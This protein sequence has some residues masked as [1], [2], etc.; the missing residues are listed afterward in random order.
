MDY[1]YEDEDDANGLSLLSPTGKYSISVPF[2][3][4]DNDEGSSRMITTSG[5]KGGLGLKGM[6][7]PPFSASASSVPTS[8]HHQNHQGHPSSSGPTT[9]TNMEQ[10]AAWDL[11]NLESVLQRKKQCLQTLRKHPPDTIPAT[12]VAGMTI[13]L[14]ESLIRE[15]T[16][17]LVHA[18][19]ATFL[20]INNNGVGGAGGVRS[21]VRSGERSGEDASSSDLLAERERQP[22]TTTTTTTENNNNNNAEMIPCKVCGRSVAASRFAPHLEKCM[23]LSGRS[24]RKNQTNKS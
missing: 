2:V 4:Q 15:I 9:P 1:Y 14:F 10:L 19:R 20:A 6:T 8:N 24:S 11:Q 3:N 12:S 17:E 5:G 13:R 16:D 21:G 18:T 22:S 7:A 23:G